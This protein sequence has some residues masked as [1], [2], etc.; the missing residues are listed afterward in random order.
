MITL[1]DERA[2]PQQK[3]KETHTMPA[4]NVYFRQG[5][6]YRICR[7]CGKHR[8]VTIYACKK[9]GHKDAFCEP[10]II[11]MTFQQRIGQ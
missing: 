10:G 9:C 2:V 3:S 7:V 6:A 5:D 1:L 8:S 11:K 4:F